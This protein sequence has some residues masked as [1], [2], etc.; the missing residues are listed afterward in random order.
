MK[1]ALPVLVFLALLFALIVPVASGSGAS[2]PPEWHG[3]PFGAFDYQFIGSWPFNSSRLVGTARLAAARAQGARVLVDLTGGNNAAY[4]DRRGCFS[5]ARWRARLDANN[6]AAL[7]SYINDGTIAALYAMDSPD[8]W[9]RCGPTG[10]DID[11]MCQYAKSRLPGVRCAVRA[12]PAWLSAQVPS[13]GYLYLDTIVAVASISDGL[14]D[15]DEWRAWEEAQRLDANAAGIYGLWTGIDIRSRRVPLEAVRNAGLAL[16]DS[17]ASGVL[18]W[19]ASYLSNAMRPVMA[20][21][22]ARCSRE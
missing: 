15:Y 13:G 5:L 21:V 8:K 19:K 9:G 17:D 12:A 16:C 18:V 4:R 14:D 7:Q 6:Y 22:A 3:K 10:A 1:R 2:A 20:E 11:A